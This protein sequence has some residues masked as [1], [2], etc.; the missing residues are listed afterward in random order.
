M[1]QTRRGLRRFPDS[2]CRGARL[3]PGRAG[4]QNFPHLSVTMADGAVMFL[5]M[6][7]SQR[8]SDVLPPSLQESEAVDSCIQ[9]SL[10]ALYP[11]FE[12]TA[13]T[14]LSQVFDVL[15][16]TFRHDALRYVIDFLI[17]AKHILQ[18]V[19][20]R[21]CAQYDGC[22]FVHEGWPLCLH[23]KVVVQLSALDWRA[24][25]PGDFYL[26]VVPGGEQGARLVLKCLGRDGCGAQE[27]A[28]PEASYPHLFSVE[29]LDGVNRGRGGRRRRLDTCLVASAGSR[30]SRTPWPRVVFPLF[31]AEPTGRQQQRRR[32]ASGDGA[33]AVVS[34]AATDDDDGCGEPAPAP[35][36]FCASPRLKRGAGNGQ[37]AADGLDG[38]ASTYRE[39]VEGEYVELLEV[40]APPVPVVSGPGRLRAGSGPAKTLPAGGG[41]YHQ[42][43]RRR[44]GAP[45]RRRAWLHRR[46]PAAAGRPGIPEK[47]GAGEARAGKES[48]NVGGDDDDDGGCGLVLESSAGAMESPRNSNAARPTDAR[49]P[50]ATSAR[51]DDD[52]DSASSPQVKE[53]EWTS[54]HASSASSPLPGVTAARD[55]RHHAEVKEAEWTSGH[56]SSASSPSP[57]VT[58]A[59]D[60]HHDDASS[61][62][63]PLSGVTG[64]VHRREQEQEEEEEVTCS[65]RRSS[66]QLAAG[67][68]GG[69]GGGGGWGGC[70]SC[71]GRHPAAA[72][73]PSLSD[74]RPRGAAVAGAGEG[75]GDSR[76]GPLAKPAGGT[77]GLPA[78]PEHVGPGKQPLAGPGGNEATGHPPLAEGAAS[79]GQ[80]LAE[81]G[82][83]LTRPRQPLVKGSATHSAPL[84]S[85]DERERSRP[86]TEGSLADEAGS[87]LK[88]EQPLVKQ[89]RSITGTLQSLAGQERSITG[90]E[91]SLAEQEGS[92]TRTEQSLA[93]QEGSITRTEQSLAE[94]EQS[95]TGTEQSLAEQERSITGTEQPLVKQERS[96]IGTEQSLAGQD[97]SV[98]GTEQSL[99]EQDRS[100]TGTEQSLAEQDR[101]ITGTEHPLA[102]QGRSLTG[103]EQSL[104][105]QERSIT[106]T[107]QSLAEQERSITGTEQSLA[108]QERS[109]TGTEQSL[110]EQERSITG[111]EHPLAQ[112]ERSLTRTEQ[113]LADQERSITGTEQSLAEQG[114]SITGTEQSLAEQERSITGTEQSL[115]EQ[116]RSITGTEQSLAEQE[117]SITGTEQSLAEQE[118]SITG[119]E[120]SLAEQERSITGTEQSLAEQERSI[121]RTEQSLAEQER[122]ITG[123]EQSLAE[124]ERSITGT[125]QSLA[126]QERSITGT[127][128][129]LAEQ[130][131]S[132]TGTEQPL[133]KQERSIIG[134][135]QSLAGQDRSVSG[136]E[137]SLAEQDRSITGTEQSLAEQDRSITG[138]E[139]PL[140]QQGRSLTGTEQSLAEQERSITGT[141]QSLAEQERSITGTEQSLAEQERS[142]TGSKHT[143]AEQERSITRSK[144]TLAANS[145]DN[146][147]APLLQ[148]SRLDR[149][150]FVKSPESTGP[151][152]PQGSEYRPRF[153]TDRTPD[154]QARRA[155]APPGEASE[156]PSDQGDR[157]S[158]C[159][160]PT[161]AAGEVPAAALGLRS[162]LGSPERG[163]ETAKEPSSGD[164]AAA[165]I[166]APLS[167]TAGRSDWRV[168]TNEGEGETG[169]ARRGEVSQM[170]VTISLTQEGF[171]EVHLTGNLPNNQEN[172]EDSSHQPSNVSSHQPSD[173]SSHQPSDASSHQPSDASS[174][175]PSDASSHQPP[176]ASSHQPP[177]ASSHQPSDASSHQLPD[178]SSHQPPDASSHQLSD[179]SSHQPL[180]ASSHQPSDASSHQ[181]SDASSHQPLKA[182]SHQPSDASPHQPSDAS[183]HQ[184]SDAS[185]HQPSDA[186]PHQPSDASPHLPS[187]ASPHQPSDAS[188]HQPSDAS[189]HQPS[190]ASP[191]QPSDA[192]PHQPS[193]ASPHL[194]SDASPHQPSDASPHQPSDASPHQP[195]DASPHQPSDASPHLPSDASPHQPSDASPHQP[196]D[197]SPHQPSDASP[198]QPSDASPHLPSD[199][200]PH[201]PSDASPHQPSDASPHQPSDVSSHSPATVGRRDACATAEKDP[202]PPDQALPFGSYPANLLKLDLDILHSGVLS[203][204]GNR[205]RN[206]RA[207]VVMT[208]KS[209]LWENPKCSSTEL[210]RIL[211]Y[212]YTISRKEV[213]DMGLRILI[214][215]RDCWPAAVLCRALDTFQKAVP[216]GIHSV[217][218]LAGKE[219]ST[220]TEGL[221]GVQVE[222]LPSVRTLHKQ[223][224][225]AQLTRAFDGDFPYCHDKWVRYRVRLESLIH[226]CRASVDFLRSTNKQLEAK[227]LP[228]SVEEVPV[229][230]QE[231]QLLMRQVLQDARLIGLQQEG[232]AILVKL[233]RETL[234]ISGSEDYRDAMEMTCALYNQVDEEVHRLVQ[235]S[236]Q[237]LK[238]LESLAEFWWFE[239]R[240][241]EVSDWFRNV[242][243]PQLE[244]SEAVGDSLPA[245]R[246]RQQEFRD[247]NHTALEYCQKG[248]GLLRHVERWESAVSPQLQPFTD[249][250]RG[251]RSQLADFTRQAER[252]RLTIDR[253]I[254]L[255][256]FFKTA[257]NWALGGIRNLACISMEQCLSPGHCEAV[258]ASLES[259]SQRHPEIPESRFREMRQ[260]AEELGEQW[261]LDQWTFCWAKCQETKSAAARKMA[262]ALGTGRRK[263]PEGAAGHGGSRTPCLERRE[264]RPSNAVVTPSLSMT[265]LSSSGPPDR[266]EWTAAGLSALSLA[267]EAS[268][269]DDEDPADLLPARRPPQR[270]DLLGA[271]SP[272]HASTPDVRGTGLGPGSSPAR[273]Q[274]SRR[275]LRKAQSFELARQAEPD[276]GWGQRALGGPARGGSVAGVLIKGLEVSST[277][278]VDRT[279]SPKEHVMLARPGSALAQAPWGRTPRLEPKNTGSKPRRALAEAL[280]AEQEY[281]S[282]LAHVVENYFPEMDRPDVP[283]DL[284]GKRGLVFGNL[285]KLLA[286]HGQC[287]LQELRGCLASPLRLGE[288]FLRHKEQFTM[289]ALYVK[290][291]PRSDALLASHGNVFFKR[292]QLFLGDRTDLASYLL[293]PIQRMM[294]YSLLLETL[295]R[296]C[297]ADT[298]QELLSLQAA[299]EMV[300]FQLRH[301]N[302]LLAMDAIRGCD[303]NLKEQGQLLRQDRFSVTCG[304][305]KSMRHIFLFEELVVFSKLKCTDGG[306][307][308]YSYKSSL[309]T[310]DLG[311][312]E[313]IGDSGLRFEVWFRRRRTNEAYVFQAESAD[314]KQAWTRDIAQILWRQASRNKELRLQ[315]MVSMGM[316]SKLVLD[317]QGS[318][319][320]SHKPAIDRVVTGKGKTRSERAAHRLPD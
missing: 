9:R 273:G 308:T 293:K 184:P 174:H 121:T 126:E 90:T 251:Y 214:D 15:E 115:A 158:T 108:E 11:P 240:F 131:R 157:R 35:G 257:Y 3:R 245:L 41:R 39:E 234:T 287:L 70:R 150:Q 103:T 316:G 47:S 17:P 318:D 89:E 175:Q 43:R 19:Q 62:A 173:A 243:Q 217:L 21:A 218:V 143:L 244:K 213:Q 300:K 249:K 38:E 88:T 23:E 298:T 204:P 100:I 67:R 171:S 301:G 49:R 146:R 119:T 53:A 78:G 306:S 1:W 68:S 20:Q 98:S 195:S 194:P 164:G 166:L 187:D 207:L 12:D 192:S 4:W 133:V 190:D 281:V 307:V 160:G 248:Q 5:F 152:K 309:K 310:A 216:G 284:R 277:E 303:V 144:H 63:S 45:A 110:A 225:P 231:D 228:E 280:A 161:Q 57:G 220:S 155:T 124:Q 294:N 64:D 7:A 223:V 191:H 193:D 10:S 44:R 232:A 127:E 106:G 180:K 181:P 56:A 197:A 201:Q 118:R 221:P 80:W 6:E 196:S 76:P 236:N 292:K 226:A 46:K 317:V 85:L 33:A 186:S 235:V 208:T 151:V 299:T 154:E 210:A 242:G 268:E 259:Y 114:R 29:W 239:D 18:T 83:P 141:E 69:G 16:K 156:A 163:E 97:R 199:A 117:R 96:I 227:R 13:A 75:E 60:R 123:T 79:A 311:L 65:P 167:A 50:R 145:D 59:R 81:E 66:N 72:S 320:A 209:L 105:E 319:S 237:R 278:L 302:N 275:T 261:C 291:K 99:A 246:Q 71:P 247:F 94:Q 253:T 279:C 230:I 101:S 153:P 36:R 288:C 122:S 26:Q 263:V 285:E 40:S 140:A 212:Y 61:S 304:R 112:Q 202:F 178:A 254:R 91:Q 135:E 262:A 169:P 252:C 305:R 258:I 93:E 264:P 205:D 25:Q 2:R 92:I 233:R 55:H 137:Q 22:L 162:A 267:S 189:P 132:I 37:D 224:E 77:T 295:I 290:N 142:I 147:S 215:A 313:N 219:S 27:V 266:K 109:I 183:P 129:S 48:S 276:C 134:T 32:R 198:H 113:S 149:Q 130:E 188:P 102:Q 260:L 185:P 148:R 104:A 107:E 286:F 52:D 222:F 84:R 31:V 172:P 159:R 176:D 289:Y 86:P 182:L 24:L 120:Q 271:F 211:M 314:V 203:L 165:A 168:P 51:D 30:L 179:A 87:R 74:A 139:H 272:V 206:G 229:L 265:S 177:D 136:T 269:D 111:T 54:G 283:Q 241:R 95:I 274:G 8:L 14:L 255:Q 270:P 58:A 312:T 200:S 282:S 42:Y 315:E 296:E 34:A 238:D 250:L 128:Q 170:E 297:D 125:E 82:A 116:E 256:E 73:T 138:T 28:V